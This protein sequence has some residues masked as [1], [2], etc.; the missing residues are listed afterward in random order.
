MREEDYMELPEEEIDEIEFETLEEE[1]SKEFARART[2][3]EERCKAANVEIEEDH[4]EILDT[5]E[6]V[7]SEIVLR[8]T[9]HAGRKD[10]K[11]NLYSLEDIER[12]LS[13]PFEKYT[14]LA[15]YRAIC[16]YADGTIEALTRPLDRSSSRV[17]Y[18]RIFGLRFREIEEIDKEN[19]RIEIPTEDEASDLT[20][21]FGSRSEAAQILTGRYLLDRPVVGMSLK[22]S[23]L[24]I[25]QHD[26]AVELLQRVANSFFFQIELLFGIPLT[27]QR[28]PR[29]PRRVRP[30]R[31]L[32]GIEQL[33]NTLQFPNYE[34]DEAPISLYWY[35]RS[36]TEM[37]L[38]QFLAYYQVIE[39]YYPTYS[40][41]EAGRRIRNIIKDPNFRSDKDTDI[42]RIL[43]TIRSHSGTGLGDERSQLRA[44]L[45]ECVDPE[46]LRRYLTSSEERKE[47]LSSRNKGVTSCKIPVANES[48]DL[49]NDAADRIYD[50]RCKIVHTKGANRD[51]ESDLILPFSSEAERLHHDI[52][53]VRYIAQKV[54]I[55]S[56]SPLQI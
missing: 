19:L 7:S 40:T 32:R 4:I 3:L 17:L 56:S 52:E 30:A 36:A 49:R 12:F 55:S 16:S 21:T 47:A 26:T 1:N 34:Y 15:N 45:Q 33:S 10:H 43:S 44:T 29:V 27:L 24:Q 48:A 11:I 53:L 41:I 28:V 35:G 39:F 6:S 9:L 25:A 8:V 18:S 20:I 13:I 5:D 14:L 31:R 22:I 38:L 54:L 2:K 37:P 23:G 46:E 51:E 50:I 42:A